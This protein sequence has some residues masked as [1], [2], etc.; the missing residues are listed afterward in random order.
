MTNQSKNQNIPMNKFTGVS[1]TRSKI[2]QLFLD[3]CFTV[4]CGVITMSNKIKIV[5]L[6]IIKKIKIINLN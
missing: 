5:L 4:V 6:I 1:N 3:A 2:W